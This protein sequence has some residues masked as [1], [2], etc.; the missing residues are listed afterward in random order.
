MEEMIIKLQILAQHQ[1]EAIASL[2]NELYSQ[3]KE[4]AKLRQQFGELKEHFQA[5][6]NEGGGVKDIG[7]ETP[8]PHY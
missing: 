2:S 3:Q 6:S 7:L 4:L 8:P 1:E 5:M